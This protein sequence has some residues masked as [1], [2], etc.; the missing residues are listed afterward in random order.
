MLKATDENK[1]NIEKCSRINAGAIYSYYHF[2]GKNYSP[3]F[4]LQQSYCLKPSKYFGYGLGAG[5]M[6]YKEQR[7]IPIY[8]EFL[9]CGE[10]NFY[11]SI[12]SGYSFAWKTQEKYYPDYDFNGG[13]Y[14]QTG[15]GYKFK[16]LNEYSSC[17]FIGYNNQSA[18]LKS[19]IFTDKVLRYNS[20]VITYGIMLETK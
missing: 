12:Q 4:Y 16:L 7:F 15:I 3:G 11:G 6:M 2:N 9:A 8:F 20:I 18:K 14:L 10:S 1:F 17:L 19:S 5:V 13:I